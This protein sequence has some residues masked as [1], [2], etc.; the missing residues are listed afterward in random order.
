MVV[1]KRGLLLRNISLSKFTYY[2]MS[3]YL[4]H[5]YRLSDKT[6]FVTFLKNLNQFFYRMKWTVL[7][8]RKESVE[9][10]YEG[11]V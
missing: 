3:S 11:R 1:G 6:M 2:A 8:D 4:Y 5:L 7:K 10:V 9:E